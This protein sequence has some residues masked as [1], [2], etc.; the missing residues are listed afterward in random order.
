MRHFINEAIEVHDKLNPLIWSEDYKLLPDVEE[1]LFKIVEY[2]K[3]YTD[4]PLEIADVHLVGSNASYNYNKTSDLDL[5]II[6]NFALMDASEELIQAAYNRERVAFNKAYDI[7]IHGISV[8]VYIENINSATM[9]N[10]IYSLYLKKWI[11]F[12]KPIKL[13]TEFDF[14]DLVSKWVDRK[15]FVIESNDSRQIKDLI[16]SAYMMRKR[17]LEIDGEY[18]KGN[19]LFKE[20]RSKGIIE[21]LKAA[22]IDV[23]SK[24]L[25]LESMNENLITEASRQSLITKSKVSNKGRQRFKRRVKS[26]VANQV[27]QFN[28]IDMD[29][30]F[31]EDILTVNVAVK[32]ETD[33]YIV[34][35][36]FG[37]F[38]DL[39]RDE[40]KR[41]KNFD[42]RAVTRALLNG[43]NKDDVYIHCSCPDFCLDGSTKIKLLNGEV[44]SVSDMLEKFNN[45]EEMW[46]YSSDE[47]G[48]FKP[49]KVSN[50]WI[51]GYV[52]SLVKVTLDNDKE[53][54]T[55]PNHRYMLRDGSY[56]EAKDLCIGQS[57]MPMYFNHKV[58]NIEFITLDESVP[59]YDISVDKYNNFYVDAGAVLHNCYRFAY[60]ATKNNINSG[61]PQNDNGKWIRN[62]DDKLGSSCKHVL[63]VLS[64]NSW[65]IK[66]A[67]VIRNYVKYMEKHYER[68]YA[69]IIYPAIYGKAYEEPVQ[70]G[71]FDDDDELASDE[72]TLDIAN[73][74]GR[75]SGQFKKGNQSGIQF[76][77]SGE[78]QQ[79]NGQQSIEDQ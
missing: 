68:Q 66:V 48:D 31:K 69:D 55:T 39:L 47:K 56:K 73:E 49:G 75:T 32:G 50:V 20:L 63:L 54:L 44:I 37:G 72:D 40:I 27:K 36:S 6:V 11:K 12:P 46:V 60:W 10:G 51:S 14:N 1:K 7:S 61:E 67:S 71:L 38:L 29:K 4:L 79:I 18:G 5:H 13:E 35:I 76:A 3:E 45:G 58:K 59:V 62:P 77:K 70:L 74:I 78:G 64:N 24:N 26:K 34:K 42:L 30:L 57:L 2:F 19:L 25:S 41:T 43:F 21:E 28:S 15:N 23:D 65:L 16:N 22:L 8:E 53:I 52:N 17:S 9:S 33:D